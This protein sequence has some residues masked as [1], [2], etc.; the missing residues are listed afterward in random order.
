MQS[1]QRWN[2]RTGYNKCLLA[3]VAD[4]N[5]KLYHV[6]DES[7]NVI[8]R[9]VV[10][11]LPFDKESP[12]L[13]VE[14]PYATRW[15]KDYGR[16]L[17]SQIAQRA[18]ELNEVLREPIAIATNDSRIEEVMEDFVKQYKFKLHSKKYERKL[19][20]SKNGFEYYDSLGGCLPSG[21]KVH[22]QLKYVFIAGE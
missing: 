6:I 1:C 20:E 17:F 15:T 21:S 2:E 19:P 22:G 3:Y 18:L 16:A 13:L 4:A 10:R 14:R 7:G 9:S 5:K 11:L 8:I 12:V